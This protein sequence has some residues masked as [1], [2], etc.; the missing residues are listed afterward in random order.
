MG[1]LKQIKDTMIELLF[2]AFSNLTDTHIHSLS[3]T[4]EGE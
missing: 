3:T 4:V 1:T 2:Y